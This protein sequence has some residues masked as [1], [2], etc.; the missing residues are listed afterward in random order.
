MAMERIAVTAALLTMTACAAVPSA[1]PPATLP[2]SPAASA[3]GKPA[4]VMGATAKHLISLFGQP[5][6][7]IRERTV[8]KLQFAN[9]R[10]VLD[11]YLY[12]PAKGKEPVVTYVDS[13][14]PD[15][16]DADAGTCVTALSGK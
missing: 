12:S 15:G 7:D 11:A 9:G 2:P 14:L 16:R 6:L 13:R 10:C 4:Q 8:R 3:Y 1:P 5:R